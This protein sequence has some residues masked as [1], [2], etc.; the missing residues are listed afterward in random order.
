MNIKVAI[1]VRPVNKREIKMGS[2][3]CVKMKDNTT[4]ILDD[5]GEV[6]RKFA[7]DHCFQSMEGY[8]QDKNGIYKKK[9]KYSTYADQ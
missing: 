7:F 8:K 6:Q 9:N 4:Y 5:D 1:R 3:V 2:E